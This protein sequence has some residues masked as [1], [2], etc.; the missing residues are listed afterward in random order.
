MENVRQLISGYLDDE[1]TDEQ[2]QTLADGSSPIQTR[3]TGL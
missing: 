3:S 1:I 2:A